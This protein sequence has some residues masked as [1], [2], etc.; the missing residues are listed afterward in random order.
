MK[1]VKLILSILVAFLILGNINAQ[2]VRAYDWC[3]TE[4]ATKERIK[5]KGGMDP[6]AKSMGDYIG[7]YIANAPKVEKAGGDKSSPYIIPVVFHCITDNGAG[8]CSKASI[9]AQINR[10]N[11]DFQRINSD[12]GSTRA[13]FKP[14]TMSMNIEFRLAHKDPNGNCTE[15]IVRT[16]SPLS[17]DATDAVKAVSY[18]DSKKYFNIW[19]V[20]SIDAGGSGGIVLGYAQFPNG[21]GGGINNTYG[22]VIGNDFVNA[23]DRTLTHE[24]GHCF[25][26]LH[27]FQSGCGWSC[28]TTGDRVCDTPP[29]SNSTFGCATSQNTCSNDATGPSVYGSNVVDQI[30]NYMSYDACQNMFTLGQKNVMEGVLNSNSTSTGLNQLNTTTNHNNTGVADPYLPAICAPIADFTYNKEYICEGGAVTFTD[31]SYNAVPTAWNWTF[32][33]GTPNTSS[34]SNPTIIYNTAGVYSVIHAPS[35]S[36]GSGMATKTNIITVSSLTA[37]YNGAVVYDFE[38]GTNYNND[39]I[40]NNPSGMGWE[41]NSTAFV[42]GSNSVRI[43]NSNTNIDGEIDVLISPSFN[44]SSLSTKTMT[45]KQAYVKK[46]SS[47]SDRLFVYYSTDCGASWSFGLLLTSANLPS[48][49]TLQSTPFIP[50]AGDW[51]TRTVNLSTVSNASNVRFK[52]EFESGG[53]ND[54]YIDDINMGNGSVSI[55]DHSNIGSFTVYPNPTKSSAQ[56]LFSLAD[57]VKSL[58]IK[59]RNSVGQEVTSVINKQSFS[60]GEYT[61]KIDRERKLASG[62]YFIEFNADDNIKVQKLIVQ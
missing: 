17:T 4:H 33:G 2:S 26:L 35:T 48:S 44:V 60:A 23:Y 46:I 11:Q 59:V 34:V 27:T 13:I 24:L 43:R 32:T 39:W 16:D 49:S 30:E 5:D 62:I 20:N 58:S 19:V 36:G 56:I 7:E 18:W 3:G 55:E 52:F 6:N 31:D 12:T 50:S 29:S 40:V 57:A 14:Y 53:G 8:Y 38:N 54:L 37:N 28:S 22:V 47:N 25:G 21:W 45:F 10:L 51:V 15:G 1:K 61:L 42:S 9:E 41:K